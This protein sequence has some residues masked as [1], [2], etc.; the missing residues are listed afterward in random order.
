MIVWEKPLSHLIDEMNN[1]GRRTKI[2]AQVKQP[3]FP[4]D[5]L[6]GLVK[7]GGLRP[8][9]P[10]DGLLR[11]PHDHEAIL[12]SVQLGEDPPLDGI[13]VLKFIN[14]EVIKV[15]LPAGSMT[16][17]LQELVG[18]DLQVIKVEAVL[19][20]NLFLGGIGQANGRQ[21]VGEGK[22]TRGLWQ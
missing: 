22:P 16:W 2:V 21:G 20:A 4:L 19:F 10:V 15:F 18:L 9:K 12:G 3:S 14:Q 1:F 8:A 6:G 13:D 7:Q 17:V 11:I 5:V